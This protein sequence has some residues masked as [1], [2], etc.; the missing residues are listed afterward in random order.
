MFGGRRKSARQ[1][2]AALCN[3][4]NLVYRA[5]ARDVFATLH[6]VCDEDLPLS[7]CTDVFGRQLQSI[8]QTHCIRHYTLQY[9]Y[10]GPGGN[11]NRCAHG[12]RRRNRGHQS[13][14]EDTIELARSQ[15]DLRAI[16]FDAIANNADPSRRSV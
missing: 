13:A 11:I 2:S 7:I 15:M 12:T 4:L 16:A 14:S 3:R 6:V 5:T 9:E 8:F 1:F 10:V